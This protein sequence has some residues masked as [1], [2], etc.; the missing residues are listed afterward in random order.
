M[1]S[2]I[3]KK[4]ICL[5]AL[6][7]ASIGIGIV[8]EESLQNHF[9]SVKTTIITQIK[10][11]T[12]NA[13]DVPLVL[14]KPDLMRGCEVTSLTMML[15]FV[16]IQVDKMELAQKIKYESFEKNGLKGNMHQGFVGDMYSFDKPGLGVY[17]EPILEIAK[18]FVP[19]ERIIN[20]SNK[21]P[22]HLYKTI[23]KGFPVWVLTNALFKE[24][25]DSQFHSWNTDVGEMKVTY[26]QHSVVITAYDEDYVYVNDPLK[27]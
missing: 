13:L 4:H 17:V 2:N 3:K 27:K 6:M 11:D 21:E 9:R 14:Q 7:L 5:L 18:L 26:Q 15:Q 25:P 24:L 19:D 20:L 1:T 22:E 23:D 8:K 10:K 12:I 16:E